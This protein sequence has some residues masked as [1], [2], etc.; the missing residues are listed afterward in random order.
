MRGEGGAYV[1]KK[2]RRGKSSGRRILRIQSPEARV[3]RALRCGI[4]VDSTITSSEAAPEHGAVSTGH[5]VVRKR[6]EGGHAGC[7]AP[8]WSLGIWLVSSGRLDLNQQR[9]APKAGP[10]PS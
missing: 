4:R 7:P 10:L 5:G 8:F 2:P 1:A 9:P 6:A 3:G